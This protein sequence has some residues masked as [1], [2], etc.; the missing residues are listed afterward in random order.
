VM[1]RAAAA[2][3][4]IAFFLAA[5]RAL[6]ERLATRLDERDGVDPARRAATLTLADV[7]SILPNGSDASRTVREVFA[8]ADALAYARETPKDDGLDAWRTRLASTL[9]ELEEGA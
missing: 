3:D 9:R 4:A 1:A 5:R 2:G 8:T 7:E 6:Q